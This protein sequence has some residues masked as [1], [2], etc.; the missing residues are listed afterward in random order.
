MNL[1]RN[2]LPEII[3]SEDVINK[4]LGDTKTHIICNR[5]NDRLI[6]VSVL[7]DNTIYLLCVD[8]AFQHK[9]IGSKLLKQSEDYI[10]SAG[11]EKI[12]LGTGKEYIMPG[13]PMNRNVH[14]FFIKRG[15]NH[16][17]G[18]TRCIDM[19]QELKDFHYSEHSVGDTIFGI[20]Y[21]WANINDLDKILVSLSDNET[22]FSPYYQNMN[23]Y[24]EGSRERVVLAEMNDEILGTLVV[25]IEPACKGM[26]SLGLTATARKHRNKGI[27]TTLVML[28]TKYLKDIG[29]EKVHGSYTYSSL[30][31]MYSKT[32]L[33]VCMEYFMGEKYLQ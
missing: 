28:A 5:A 17:W 14:N 19:E 22:D 6:G 13:V 2:T 9:G 7:E 20:K 18:N 32:G 3:R 8:K 4:I 23:Y 15:Y 12:V 16:S 11:H 25:S 21:R 31:N 26:G 29:M 30:I 1:F 27:A 24:L 10:A 33:N